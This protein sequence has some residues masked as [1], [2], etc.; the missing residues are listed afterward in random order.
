MS[1]SG[2]PEPNAQFSYGRATASYQFS[3]PHTGYPLQGHPPAST[4]TPGVNSAPAIPRQLWTTSPSLRGDPTS[5][6][7][8]HQPTT[9]N[10]LPCENCNSKYQCVGQ[11][12]SPV[13]HR[14]AS[15]NPTY[16][17]TFDGKS[18]SIP[19]N[20]RDWPRA[21]G[22]NLTM[23]YR[24]TNASPVPQNQLGNR[25]RMGTAST[26]PSRPH[27]LKPQG[28]LEPRGKSG[29]PRGCIPTLDARLSRLENLLGEVIPDAAHVLN[30]G[31]CEPRPPKI[32]ATTDRWALYP[33]QMSLADASKRRIS[34]ELPLELPE[35]PLLDGAMEDA[36]LAGQPLHDRYAGKT[37]QFS[38]R[39]SSAQNTAS[40][41]VFHT[42]HPTS[43][44]G[45]PVWHDL[46][47]INTCHYSTFYGNIVFL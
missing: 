37:Q 33:S 32:S 5:N 19:S 15:L 12:E 22:Q 8:S 4:S 36:F 21:P 27:S 17:T 31:T 30:P 38:T 29:P 16:K 44:Q 25:P 20:L 45:K 43:P 3:A 23:C 26:I 11:T 47:G 24:P 9:S 34:Q 18:N 35:D 13:C 6:S 2:A 14:C 39:Q 7:G 41:S 10:N 46:L 28:T 1:Y 42:A 40:F